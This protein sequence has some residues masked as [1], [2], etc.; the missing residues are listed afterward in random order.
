MFIHFGINTFYTVYKSMNELFDL[1][2]IATAQDNIMI[3]D[4]P[5]NRSG[6]LREKNIQLVLL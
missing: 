2:K 3:L 5:P 4:L 1:Y 6:R